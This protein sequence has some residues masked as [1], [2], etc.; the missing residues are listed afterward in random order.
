[1][2]LLTI[3]WILIGISFLVL[4]ITRFGIKKNLLTPIFW[5]LFGVNLIV[6][7]IILWHSIRGS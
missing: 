2:T 5:L 3:F 4:A 6:L 7:A 1:M